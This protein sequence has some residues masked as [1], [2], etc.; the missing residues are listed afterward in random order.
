MAIW[1]FSRSATGAEVELSKTRSLTAV[2]A[3][4]HY[5]HLFLLLMNVKLNMVTL[6]PYKVAGGILAYLMILLYP[7]FF[8]RIK[9]KKAIHAIYFLYV[10]FVMAMTYVARMGGKFEGASPELFHKVGLGL[11]LASMIYFIYT[12]FVK[13]Q[14]IQG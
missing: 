12:K 1:Q 13:Q 14:R 10:G 4:L 7:I 2:F 9:N 6:I 3:V 8:E 11:V 5:I